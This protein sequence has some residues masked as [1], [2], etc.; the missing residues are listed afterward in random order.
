MKAKLFRHGFLRHGFFSSGFQVWF[1][2][3]MS[4]KSKMIDLAQVQ[5]FSAAIRRV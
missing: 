5:A 2:K 4:R 3:L 1:F